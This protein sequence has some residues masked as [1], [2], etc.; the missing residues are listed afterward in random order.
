MSITHVQL[1]TPPASRRMPS[2]AWIAFVGLTAAGTAAYFSLDT[3]TQSLVADGVAVAAAAAMFAGIAVSRP[4]PRFA[5]VLLAFGVSLLA[6]GDIAYGTAQPV[7]STADMLYVSAYPMLA[8]GLLALASGRTLG[9][10]SVVL[11]GVIA[12]GVVAILG[13]VFLA[14]P[15]GQEREVG[16]LTRLI[17]LGYPVMDLVLLAILFR[18]ARRAISH[19]MPFLLLGAAL[20]LHL[21]ADLGFALM[22]Y[23]TAYS[24]G[25]GLDAAWLLGF[26]CF[27]AA[28]LHPAAANAL[29]RPTETGWTSVPASSASGALEPDGT[30]AVLRGL[31]GAPVVVAGL[32]PVADGPLPAVVRGLGSR[33]WAGAVRLQLI[34]VWAGL[35]LLGL[36]GTAML[37]SLSWGSTEVAALSGA[38]AITGSFTLL[39]S[40]IR[41]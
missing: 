10:R 24:V 41:A 15:A 13:L 20:L 32:E 19:G 16:T 35:L 39:A 22:N 31:S 29:L 4:E 40:A 25:E 7:P 17:A 12:A 11:G 6:A 34:L 5:W 23:G 28:L 9:G 33:R 2:F 27:G 30:T 1:P 37:A 14:V 8:F 26:A 21:G 3:Q 36:A 18:P 38:Y